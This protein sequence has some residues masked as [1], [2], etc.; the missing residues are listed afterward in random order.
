MSSL[1]FLLFGVYPYV[2]LSVFL[3]GSWARYDL[4]SYTWKAHSSQLLSGRHMRIA[5]N[6]FHV[7]VLFIL[8]GHVIGLLTPHAWYE[9][10]ISTEHK[11]LL[12]MISGGSFGMVCLVGLLMLIYRRHT[13]ARVRHISNTSDIVILW[14]LLAQLLL[15]LSSILVSAQHL[16]G[17]EMILLAHWA[18]S[19]VTLQ[20]EL[21]ASYMRTVNLIFKLHV[22]LGLTLFILFPF[23]RLVHIAS[24][25]IW[26][27][28]RRYQI[29]RQRG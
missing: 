18:Q 25:P 11:Q 13:H 27:L 28:G 23:T 15:G 7:G 3:V 12:A 10:V 16:D 8:M 1:N 4:S 5:S 17:S 9:H 14:I 19:I 26:Y 6:L 22:T 2:A 20:P 21:A 29:V 24:A